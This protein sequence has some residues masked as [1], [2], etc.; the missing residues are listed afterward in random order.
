M[1]L[2][3][4]DAL[5]RAVDDLADAILEFVELAVTLG[6]AHLLHD[7]CLADWAAMRPKSIGGSGSAI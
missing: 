3:Y 5:D 4:F 7:S 1:T 2:P 6:F